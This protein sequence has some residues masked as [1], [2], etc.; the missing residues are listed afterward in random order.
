MM[1]VSKERSK[2]MRKECPEC[3][4]MVYQLFVKQAPANILTMADRVACG[5]CLNNLWAIN[6]EKEQAGK[7]VRK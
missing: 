5:Y 7:E 1:V 6:E 3:G 4:R 2:G